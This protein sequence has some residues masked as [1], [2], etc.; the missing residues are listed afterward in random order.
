MLWE[1]LILYFGKE[2]DWFNWWGYVNDE[3]CF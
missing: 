2:D 1:A 3:V